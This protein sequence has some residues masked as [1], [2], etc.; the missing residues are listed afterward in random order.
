MIPGIVAQQATILSSGF[1]TETHNYSYTGAEETLTVPAGAGYARL[2]LWGGG[3]CGGRYSGGYYGGNG[4]FTD[5][6]IEVTPGDVLTIQTAQGGQWGGLTANSPGGWP[7]GGK[8]SWGD[9]WGG[10]GGGSSRVFLNGDLVAVAGGGGGATGWSSNAGGGGGMVGGWNTPGGQGGT[11]TAGGAVSAGSD[12]GTGPV[13]YATRTDQRG[14]NG[15]PQGS[16]TSVDGGGGG[17]GY[18]GGGGGGSNYPGGGGSGFFPT[19]YVAASAF[20]GGADGSVAAPGS[21]DAA[22]PGVPVAVGS[23]SQSNVA[24]GDGF[25]QVELKAADAFIYSRDHVT[26]A[27][28]VADI[29]IIYSLRKTV[30][31]YNGPVVRG[32]RVSDNARQDFYPTDGGWIDVGEVATWAGSSDVVVDTW[33]DQSANGRH[34][35]PRSTWGT[36]NIPLLAVAGVV[37][38]SNGHPAIMFG[39]AARN[40]WSGLRAPLNIFRSPHTVIFGGERNG[41]AASDLSWG[42]IISGPRNGG[43]VSYGYNSSQVPSLQNNGSS[44]SSGGTTFGNGVPIILGWKAAA[45]WAPSSTYTVTPYVNKTASSNRSLAYG[46]A[47]LNQE[48]TYMGVAAVGSNA[49]AGKISEFVFHLTALSDTDR[50]TIESAMT[51]ALGY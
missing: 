5:V 35:T 14:G 4:G 13:T 33:Y 3:G 50:G 7:D 18:Y 25:V 26:A 34:A 38:T 29:A 45:A 27:W 41:W 44:D 19:N 31:E 12:A 16:S 36:G 22:Y 10:G 24:G 2:K 28:G 40:T 21:S 43:A 39:S 15:G 48:T 9:V 42:T 23:V 1:V 51:A 6:T 20:T 30:P 32:W 17:G 49:F 47:V 46:T 8:G 37:P 11:Q